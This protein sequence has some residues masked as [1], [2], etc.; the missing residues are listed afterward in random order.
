MAVRSIVLAHVQESVLRRKSLRVRAVDKT[1]RGLATD[2][3]D[4]VIE[5]HGA[6]LAAP[7]IGAHWR[8][9]VVLNDE[10]DVVPMINPEIVRST[11]LVDDFEGCLSFPG[12]WGR[13]ER[14]VTVTVKFLDLNGR[15]QRMKVSNITARAVQHEIDHLDGI[16]FVDRLSEPGKLY[17]LDYDEDDS[18]IYVPIQDE[19]KLPGALETS[20]RVH[21]A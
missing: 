5:N 8:V 10:G 20:G 16:L 11:G 18:P 13:V 3:V 6:G 12:L 9:C 14:A 19:D 15:P 21:L 7:Q 2:L 17:R 4:T 1:I